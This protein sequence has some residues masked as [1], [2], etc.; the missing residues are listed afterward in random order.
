MGWKDVSLCSQTKTTTHSQRLDIYFGPLSESSP[1]KITSWLGS[2]MLR[3]V[4]AGWAVPEPRY[5]VE[6]QALGTSSA[7]PRPA[8]PCPVPAQA[9][10]SRAALTI[11]HST[12]IRHASQINS[13]PVQE[14]CQL[15]T[16][17]N[18]AFVLCLQVQGQLCVLHCWTQKAMWMDK[19]KR[20]PRLRFCKL[21]APTS[22]TLASLAT[23]FTASSNVSCGME[24]GTQRNMPN[25]CIRLVGKDVLVF[26]SKH[27]RALHL[28]GN[29]YITY[30]FA[31]IC[32]TE[33]KE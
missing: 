28:L 24:K 11:R 30:M 26:S 1:W 17:D 13:R 20:T 23:F 29:F 32:R 14:N 25:C 7:L 12:A 22:P 31:Y 21:W 5:L 19:R 18:T 27:F 33:R 16:R 15:T 4:W 10:G 8:P 3:R 9:L 2:M 6:N